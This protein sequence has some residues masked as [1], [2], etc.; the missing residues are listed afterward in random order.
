VICDVR[1][2]IR[3]IAGFYNIRNTL[4]FIITV[5]RLLLEV[6]RFLR[7][8]QYRVKCVFLLLGEYFPS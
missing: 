8:K 3:E 2:R 1:K 6:A 4:G 5:L 7:S